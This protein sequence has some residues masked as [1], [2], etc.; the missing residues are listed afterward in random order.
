MTP[1]CQAPLQGETEPAWVSREGPSTARQPPTGS[2]RGLR[3]AT[4]P[5][6]PAAVQR[7]VVS[8]RLSPLPGPELL[9]RCQSRRPARVDMPL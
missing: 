9:A 4:P 2:G 7:V 6:G 8:A 3:A 5:A 1:W